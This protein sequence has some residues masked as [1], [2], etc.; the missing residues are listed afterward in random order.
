MAMLEKLH[1]EHQG[2]LRE[3]A[4]KDTCLVDLRD[5]KVSK[6]DLQA[7]KRYLVF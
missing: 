7:I 6:N 4:L 3:K 2:R 5:F 1:E